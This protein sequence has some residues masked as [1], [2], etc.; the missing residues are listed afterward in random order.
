METKDVKKVIEK[1]QHFSKFIDWKVF[2][3][4][5]K[6][7]VITANP[8]TPEWDYLI[9][10]IGLITE[11]TSLSQDSRYLFAMGSLGEIAD[12]NAETEDELEEINLEPD[13]YTSQL[14]EWLNEHNEH[15]YY[16]TQAIEEGS[17]DG[18]NALSRAQQIAGEEVYRITLDW[19][20]EKALA[21]DLPY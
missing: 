5:N 8:N 20:K 12:S 2:S 6:R 19:L 10:L 3:E 17:Q 15:V 21:D 11:G 14:T 1:A 18:F 13:I 4:D 16:L 7:V 9:Q